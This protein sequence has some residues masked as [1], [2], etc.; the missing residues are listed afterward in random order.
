MT[1]KL[2]FEELGEQ[3]TDKYGIK[4]WLKAYTSQIIMDCITTIG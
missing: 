2:M 1:E 3:T 4:F